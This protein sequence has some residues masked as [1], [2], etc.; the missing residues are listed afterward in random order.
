MQSEDLPFD[1]SEMGRASILAKGAA[2][3]EFRE[4]LIALVHTVLTDCAVVQSVANEKQDKLLSD[5][6]DKLRFSI[7]ELEIAI[8]GIPKTTFVQQAK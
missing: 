6:V 1:P 4:H 5:R 2:M 8:D 3:N 7:G